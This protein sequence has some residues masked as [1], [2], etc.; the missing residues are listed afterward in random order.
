MTPDGSMKLCAR[1]KLVFPLDAFYAHPRNRD[2]RDCYCKPCAKIRAAV[3]AEANADKRR[4]IREKWK[5]ANREKIAESN[6]RYRK[7]N[8]AKVAVIKARYNKKPSTKAVFHERRRLR[9]AS[10]RYET[11]SKFSL[12]DWRAVLAAFNHRCAY[13]GCDGRMTIEHLEPLSRG[14][15]NE[16][17]N[18]V[19]ACLSCNSRKHA[20]TVEEFAPHL[21]P[22]IRRVADS[23]TD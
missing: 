3:W 4:A 20:K 1:C 2:G 12:S 10:Q 18:I 14:G 22:A 15:T 17:G 11:E 23:F 6:S 13:C 5:A 9:R 21:A 7:A 16:R 8:P 19:P